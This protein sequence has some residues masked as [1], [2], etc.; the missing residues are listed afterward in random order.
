[1]RCIKAD[2]K[3]SRYDLKGIIGFVKNRKKGG[4]TETMLSIVQ[5]IPEK[6]M[7][8]IITS[9]ITRKAFLPGIISKVNKRLSDKGDIMIENLEME[10]TGERS[11]DIK[12]NLKFKDYAS[13]LPLIMGKVG[14]KINDDRLNA[15]VNTAVNVIFSEVPDDVKDNVINGIISGAAPEI[16]G[17]ANDTLKKKDIPV[18]LGDIGIN[19]GKH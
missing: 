7:I 16:C 6:L 13:F 10:N 9:K 14:D 12:L 18:Q 5:K 11:L 2:V 19:A 4:K 8:S 15:I 17:F 3:I 1:M